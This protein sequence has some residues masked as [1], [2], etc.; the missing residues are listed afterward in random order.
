VLLNSSQ[1]RVTV[2]QLTPPLLQDSK[3]DFVLGISVLCTRW[4]HK[5]RQWFYYMNINSSSVNRRHLFNPTQNSHEV[6]EN[7]ALLGYYAASNGNF[8]PTLRDNLSGLSSGVK[9]FLLLKMVPVGCPKTSVKIYHYS[10]RNK[11]KVCSSL[12]NTDLI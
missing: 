5:S 9:N 8:L 3:S 7:C 2:Y 4:L 12:L 1:T 6:D 10:L 11:P